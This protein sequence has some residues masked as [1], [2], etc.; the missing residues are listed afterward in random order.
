[1][2]PPAF[3]GFDRPHL[4][5]VIEELADPW[6]ARCESALRERRGGDRRR[7]ADAGPDHTVVFTDRVLVTVVYLPCACRTRRWPSFTA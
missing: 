7:A 3:C 5:Y 2:S 4:G 1:M 6:T